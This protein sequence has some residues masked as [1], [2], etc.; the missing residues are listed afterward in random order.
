MHLCSFV[1]LFPLDS[2]Y[3]FISFIFVT[4]VS[5]KKKKKKRSKPNYISKTEKWADLFLNG[6]DVIK[7]EASVVKICSSK[8]LLC[9]QKVIIVTPLPP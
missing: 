4:H 8:M 9:G 3:M 7:M 2:G 1:F 5:T 6:D